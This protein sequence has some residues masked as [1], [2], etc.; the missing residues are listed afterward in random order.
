MALQIDVPKK[1]IA[2]AMEVVLPAL[3]NGQP[4]SREAMDEY[5]YLANLVK[6]NIR[7]CSVYKAPDIARLTL[8]LSNNPKMLDQTNITL[9]MGEITRVLV[10]QNSY[11]APKFSDQLATLIA[12]KAWDDVL[13]TMVLPIVDVKLFKIIGFDK[14]KGV[15]QSRYDYLGDI[16]F[17][18][19]IDQ[20]N[21]STCSLGFVRGTEYISRQKWTFRIHFFCENK[22]TV[23]GRLG[24]YDFW[25]TVTATST[26]IE[27]ELDIC[28]DD[29][30]FD[31]NFIFERDDG[32][33]MTGR[34][35]QK[36]DDCDFLKKLLK[37]SKAIVK[38]NDFIKKSAWRNEVKCIGNVKAVDEGDLSENNLLVVDSIGVD[39]WLH[40]PQKIVSIKSLV[41]ITAHV[42]IDVYRVDGVYVVVRKILELDPTIGLDRTVTNVFVVEQLSDLG[43]EFCLDPALK[44][45]LVRLVDQHDF[46]HVFNQEKVST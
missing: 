18:H 22:N 41:F 25:L 28:I 20:K 4:V 2:D 9:E 32:S 39:Y 35:S 45:H 15:N 33:F 31:A 36:Y 30:V 16:D 21:N 8:G 14:S 26:L 17:I 40:A 46:P 5:T 43:G 29:V 34:S 19:H 24:D 37:D 38:I 11:N 13:K 12:N 27:K 42:E 6:Y 7:V 10:N 44:Q 1:R 3:T 23:L